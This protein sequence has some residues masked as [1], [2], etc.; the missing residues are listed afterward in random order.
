MGIFSP[1]PKEEIIKKKTEVLR[2][3]HSQ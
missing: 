3:P 1:F 2:Q